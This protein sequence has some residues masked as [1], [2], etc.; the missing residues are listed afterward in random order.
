MHLNVDNIITSLEIMGKG[1]GSIFAVILLLTLIVVLLA[2]FSGKK[3]DS[4]ED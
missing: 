1:M 4:K 2:K 3:K